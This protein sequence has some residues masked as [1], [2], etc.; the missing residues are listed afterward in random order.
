[1]ALNLSETEYRLAVIAEGGKQYDISDFVTEL[2][3]EENENE[4]AMRISFAIRNGRTPKGR[5]SALI[6]P[7]CLIGVFAAAGKREREVV[8]G[9]I[10]S[11]DLQIRN[12]GNSLK[13]ICYDELYNLQ[14]SQDNRYYPS[15]T[16]TKAIVTGIFDEW[17][18]PTK[19]YSG[20]DVS[21]GKLKYSASYLSDILLDVLEDAKKKGAG[22]Y[23]VRAAGGYVDVVQRGGNEEVFVFKQDITESASTN[24]STADLI[25]RVKVCGPQGSDGESGFEDALDGLT[26]YGIRQRIYMRGADESL[27]DAR[28]AAQN[29]LDEEG[30]IKRG[31]TL[32]AP[33]VP[34][35]R[36][37]D[38]V[39]VTA[40]VK[41]A[42]YYVKGIRHDC[43]SRSM[44]M[45]LEKA[46]THKGSTSSGNVPAGTK[47]YNVGDSV[48]F[49][50]GTH[51]ISSYPD[52]RG[53]PASAGRAQITQKNGSGK[54]HPWH[55]IHAGSDSNVYGWVDDG[56]FE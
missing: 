26:E 40:G 47:D 16:G 11:W 56:T 20:P 5:L 18:I 6:K 50:G 14:K 54:V 49:K 1:M 31:I 17:G 29:I 27:E 46:G 19:G 48:Y 43:E 23:V 28:A 34:F 37:G 38:L 10:T 25:T 13:C 32:Q 3:W 42:Y 53:Y 2:G 44:I 55:L 15:G 51:Y 45:E 33:D 8:R 21:H 12:S 22:K 7:G 9:Y 30:A 35:I 24:V 36:K 4:I 41:D 39:Y 52:A